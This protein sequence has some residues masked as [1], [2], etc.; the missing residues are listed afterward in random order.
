[1][2]VTEYG[3]DL[4]W[5]IAKSA[6]SRQERNFQY[7]IIDKGFRVKIIQDNDSTINLI[8]SHVLGPFDSTKF[9][10]ILFARDIKLKL[11]KIQSK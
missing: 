5:I 3:Y 2:T 4:N 10:Q 11:K 1:M 8:K 9:V 6:L 7:W